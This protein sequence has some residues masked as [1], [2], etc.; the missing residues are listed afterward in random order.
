[1]E[2]LCCKVFHHTLTAKTDG[3]FVDVHAYMELICKVR[4][5][6]LEVINQSGELFIWKTA[7]LC[8]QFELLNDIDGVILLPVVEI[9]NSLLPALPEDATLEMITTPEILLV[10]KSAFKFDQT[11][12]SLPFPL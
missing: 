2:N 11:K 8:H 5:G 6:K 9:S 10:I 3:H 4:G 1:M 12:P 7:V